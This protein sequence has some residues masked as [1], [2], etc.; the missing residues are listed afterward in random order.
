MTVQDEKNQ[1]KKAHLLVTF[2]ASCRRFLSMAQ[3]VHDAT[4]PW[5]RGGRAKDI[6]G[7][8]QSNAEA[9]TEIC[10]KLLRGLAAGQLLLRVKSDSLHKY[11]SLRR[12]A[13]V[14]GEDSH[15]PRLDDPSE[16]LL[17]LVCSAAQE[18]A[19]HMRS[20]WDAPP[21]WVIDQSLE[22]DGKHRDFTLRSMDYARW[23]ILKEFAKL[24]NIFDD[25]DDPASDEPCEAWQRDA[26][27][28][29]MMDQE[30]R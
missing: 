1:L 29:D 19:D 14:G 2:T 17:S 25:H 10:L 16:E 4:G 30:T 5:L 20:V 24:V 28:M 9:I 18:T 23:Q 3:V 27:A 15:E 21:R 8:S 11:D 26:L 6:I 22:S 7:S 13:M 12:E